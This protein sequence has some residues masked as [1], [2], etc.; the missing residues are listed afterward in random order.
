MNPH[1]VTQDFE[2]ALCEYTGAPYA[3]VV[4]SCTMA[5]L[6]ALTARRML[7]GRLR[8]GVPKKT[9]LSVPMTVQQAG[10]DLY[11]RDLEWRGAYNLEGTSI[12]DC[13]RRFTGGMWQKD[14]TQCVS[15][16]ASKVLNLDASVGGRLE[17]LRKHL[18]S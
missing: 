16:H 17:K 6:I 7:L 13:A 9:Y 14:Q 1:K 10:H 18:A 2:A 3:C 15:F 4:T 12:W 11:F 5:L 8:V